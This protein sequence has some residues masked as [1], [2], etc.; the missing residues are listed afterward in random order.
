M[1]GRW[2]GMGSR[3]DDPCDILW[4]RAGSVII[5]LHSNTSAMMGTSNPKD[6]MKRAPGW[7][8]GAEVVGRIHPGASRLK[9][10]LRPA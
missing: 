3:S 4:A 6:R 5:N 10:C 7:C 2:D 8:E 9:G 1:D